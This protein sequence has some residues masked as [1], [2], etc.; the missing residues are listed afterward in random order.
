MAKVEVYFKDYC[1]YCHKA[2]AL[3]DHKD[4][5]YQAYDITH[6]EAGQKE[7]AKRKPGARTVPQIFINDEGIGGC[8]ELHS[9]EAEGK[10]DRLLN[11]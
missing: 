6:D 10:L 11:I 3:L 9:L 4:I 5:E 1:P 2:M 7:M 8:D